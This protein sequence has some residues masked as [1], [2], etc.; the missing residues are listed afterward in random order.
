LRAAIG[1]CALGGLVLGYF[2]LFDN[3]MLLLLPGVNRWTFEHAYLFARTILHIVMYGL[4]AAAIPV[5][6]GLISGS[7]LGRG[8][9][10]LLCLIPSWTAAEWLVGLIVHGP[11]FE[12]VLTVLLQTGGR[13]SV[14]HMLLAG[15]TAIEFGVLGT[16]TWL[17][18]RRFAA[19]DEHTIRSCRFGLILGAAIGIAGVG[20]GPPFEATFWNPFGREFRRWRDYSGF[21]FDDPARLGAFVLTNGSAWAVVGAAVGAIFAAVPRTAFE[22][23]FRVSG[24]GREPEPG[25]ESSSAGPLPGSDP[26]AAVRPAPPSGQTPVELPAAPLPA[27]SQSDPPAPTSPPD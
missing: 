5:V 23:A 8:A 16:C 2:R 11:T 17:G 18:M 21:S 19:V 3:D 14:V 1:L 27:A 20:V 24:D 7:P 4:F 25:V 26:P 22:P 12:S 10:L 6:L 15:V 9:R 13:E